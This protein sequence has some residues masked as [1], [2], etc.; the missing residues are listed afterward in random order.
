MKII[1]IADSKENQVK[2]VGWEVEFLYSDDSQLISKVLEFKPNII[3]IDIHNSSLR[4][5]VCKQ[6]KS[7]VDAQVLI[8]LPKEESLSLDSLYID[9][10]MLKPFDPVE[11]ILR[12]DFAFRK[13]HGYDNHEKIQVENLIIDVSTY[14]V[15]VEGKPIELT[16]KE[17]EL[18]KL[19]VSN[20]RKVFSRTSLLNQI[21]GYDYYGG[22]R[23]VD[24]HIRRLRMKLGSR[25]GSLIRTVHNVGY[26]FAG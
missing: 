19:F 22:T 11:L 25:Y 16:F 21:W 23:T 20:K 1:V 24:V 14:E 10:F 9:D 7:Y 18:L 6:S 12:V 2:G 4:K 5:Q 17:Y 13:K 26:K 3:V 15:T 8:L